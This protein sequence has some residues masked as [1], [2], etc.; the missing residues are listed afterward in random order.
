MT[1]PLGVGSGGTTGQQG[2]KQVANA[3]M[4]AFIMLIVN[5]IESYLIIN[6]TGS[7]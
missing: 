7:H 5:K 4:F 2:Q 6:K 1:T 3:T